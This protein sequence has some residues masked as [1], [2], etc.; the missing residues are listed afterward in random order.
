MIVQNADKGKAPVDS[1]VQEC[2][3]LSEMLDKG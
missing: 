2:P 1:S 3:K